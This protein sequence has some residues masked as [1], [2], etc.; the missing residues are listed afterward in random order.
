MK[1]TLRT[2]SGRN[3]MI[4]VGSLYAFAKDRDRRDMGSEES[5]FK[6]LEITRGKTDWLSLGSYS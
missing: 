3:E 4:L 6:A 1:L 2:W 5:P